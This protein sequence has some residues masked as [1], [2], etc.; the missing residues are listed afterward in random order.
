MLVLPDSGVVTIGSSQK[1]PSGNKDIYV[2]RTDKKGAIQWTKHYGSENNDEGL[3]MI[4]ENNIN[5]VMVGYT[6]KTGT[7]SDKDI[8][9][10]KIDIHGNDVWPNQRIRN[11]PGDNT[12]MDIV[13]MNDEYIV[14]GNTIGAF[15]QYVNPELNSVFIFKTDNQ[16]ISTSSFAFI[17]DNGYGSHYGTMI[18]TDPDG[19]FYILG[20][21][22]SNAGTSDILL[23]RLNLTLNIDPGWPKYLDVNGN[24]SGN[25][26]IVT[27]ENLHIIGSIANPSGIESM[28]LCITD[29]NGN[30]G[31]QKQYNLIDNHEGLGFSITSDGG[32]IITGGSGKADNDKSEI[33]VVKTKAGGVL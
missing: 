26:L 21:A 14:M 32:Y 5:L 18:E 11:Y 3:G 7:D 15:E 17:S 16:G 27:R 9:M 10:F 30:I 33:V 25:A 12:A 6:E 31:R 23:A 2:V 28:I 19:Y 24:T 20:K 29:K 8:W 4:L 1:N 22:E 13:P